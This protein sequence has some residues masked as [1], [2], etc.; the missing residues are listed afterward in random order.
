MLWVLLIIL[1]TLIFAG[2]NLFDKFILEKRLQQNFWVYFVFGGFI[3]LI[4]GLIIALF[5]SP[6]HYPLLIILLSILSGLLMGLNWLLF[7]KAIT[8][9]E[10]SRVISLIYLFPIFVAIAAKFLLNEKIIFIKWIAIVLAIVGAILISIKKDEV[11]KS[12]RLSP[13]FFY[14]IIIATLSEPAVE[15]IDKYVLTSVSPWH[16]LSLNTMGFALIALVFFA[17]S[18][19][20]RHNI[21]KLIFNSK[22]F[23][24]V[25]GA[26][27][28]YLLGNLIFLMAAAL[29]QITYVA[30]ISAVQPVFVFILTV[31]SSLATPQLLKESLDKR[32]LIIKIVS[33]LLV[34][35]SVLIIILF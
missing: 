27:L 26:H 7:Y 29:A 13:A 31:I 12:F 30:A 32:T 2:C 24:L 19:T 1:S 21:V 35:S 5:S 10:V 8:H 16:L 28:I 22:N 6:F 14:V 9:E 15:I 18:K 33:I 20:I 3:W 17:I 25:G 34:V 23:L 4:L 11:K